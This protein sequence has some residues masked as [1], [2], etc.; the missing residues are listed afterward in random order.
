MSE[1]T[2]VSKGIFT[3]VFIFGLIVCLGFVIM[4]SPWFWVG[5]PFLLTGMTGVFDAM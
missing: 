2:E 4:M 1:K 3:G 5:L